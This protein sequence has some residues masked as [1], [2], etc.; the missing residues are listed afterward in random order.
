MAQTCLLAAASCPGVNKVL[1]SA[2]DP[3]HWGQ[4]LDALAH[5]P[6]PPSHL[7]KALDVLAA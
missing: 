4:A 5:G 6:V 2:T 3:A 7:R 1:L